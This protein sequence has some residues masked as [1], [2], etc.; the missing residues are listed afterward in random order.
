M[1]DGGSSVLA[2]GLGVKPSCPAEVVIRYRLKSD[3]FRALGRLMGEPARD[4]G[5]FAFFQEA[6]REFFRR[7]P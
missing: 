3:A 1:A 2:E 5:D 4:G 6:C 7:K